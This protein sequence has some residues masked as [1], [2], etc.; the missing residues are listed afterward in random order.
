M[1][2]EKIVKDWFEKWESGNYSDLPISEN[3]K[4]TSPFGT[5]D[6]RNAYLEIV[7]KNEDKFLGQT[8]DLHDGMYDQNHACVR[9]TAKQG[10]KFRLDVSEW[11]YIKNNTIE[12]IVSYYH[13]GEI[14]DDRK[15]KLQE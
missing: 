12:E 2:S 10:T 9:Y 14:R 5:I 7:Q 1:N 3:F 6:G 8:F 13:I 4:H 11:Y 15:L